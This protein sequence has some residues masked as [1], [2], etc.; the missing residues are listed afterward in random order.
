MK[1]ILTSVLEEAKE[2]LYQDTAMA[3]DLICE[4][5]YYSFGIHATFYGKSIYVDN[6]RV[7]SIKACKEAPQ[8][9]GIYDYTILVKQ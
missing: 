1:Q 6:I 2:L 5:L 8:T 3:L 4:K 9:I 7:A